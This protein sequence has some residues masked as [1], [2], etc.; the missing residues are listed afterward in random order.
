MIAFSTA[1]Q[2]VFE[3]ADY[4]AARRTSD[5]VGVAR[6]VDRRESQDGAVQPEGSPKRTTV[7]LTD[8][9]ADAQDRG[10]PERM[11]F[12]HRQPE[13][14]TV[15]LV[16]RGKDDVLN[17]EAAGRLQH[18]ERTRNVDCECLFKVTDLVGSLIAS[19]QVV[20]NIRTRQ[21]ILDRAPVSDVAGHVT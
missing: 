21:G 9:L 17:A 15:D 5:R 14:L 8:H 13:R 18:V 10:G 2:P 3:I 16:G 4:S 11:G 6:T 20:G 1:R 19:S 7:R 12:F